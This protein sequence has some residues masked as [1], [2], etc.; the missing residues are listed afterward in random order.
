MTS[1]REAMAL[2][3]KKLDGASVGVPARFMDFTFPEDG[4]PLFFYDQNALA[5]SLFAVFSAIFPPG[6]RFF[7]ETVRRYADRVDDPTLKAQVSGFM[8][9]ES[10]HGRQHERL[11][12]WYAARG[13]D[14]A[15]PERLIR[16]SLALLRRLPPSQQLACTTLMEHFTA[17]LAE[18]WLT[19]EAFRGAADP[20]M[21]GLWVWHGL[22][23]LEHKSVAFDVH[24]LV[25]ANEHLERVL[26]FPIVI[27][28]LLPGVLVSLGALVVQQGEAARWDEHRRG[29]EVLFGRDGFLRRVL[30]HLPEYLEKDFHPSK[31]D[32]TALE[33][34]WRE[35]LFGEGGAL[36]GQFRNRQAVERRAASAGTAKI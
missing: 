27:A 26:A 13:F 7:V 12:Q 22:E 23:E 14:L 15:V 35:R 36:L 30:R 18:Q 6:E 20:E 21:L 17:H 16:Q 5:S 10:I 29:V 2:E 25:S 11:N 3:S 24:R 8:G 1:T 31:R 34:E 32:T 4:S 28:A 19:D 9:Q 33:A